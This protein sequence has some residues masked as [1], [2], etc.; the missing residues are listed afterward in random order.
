MEIIYN[1]LFLL[2]F[3]ILSI[4]LIFLL[5]SLIYFRKK[6]INNNKSIKKPFISIIIP[7]YNEEKDILET[8]ESLSKLT[9]NNIEILLINDGSSDKSQKIVE[10]FIQN[11]DKFKL[12]NNTK[13]IGKANSLNKGIKLAKGELIAC[14]DADTITDD[15]IFEKIIPYFDNKKVGAVV[16]SILVKKQN[17]LIQKGIAV[18]YFLMLSI[19][20]KIISFYNSVFVT[21]GQFSVF[22]KD[23]LVKIKGFDPNNMAEDNEIAFRIQKAKYLIKSCLE[24]KV[25]TSVPDNFKEL[26]VQRKRW[27]FGA[28]QTYFKHKNMMFKKQYSNFGIIAPITF[29]LIILGLIFMILY[30]FKIIYNVINLFISNYNFNVEE[31]LPKIFLIIVIF[32]IIVIFITYSEHIFKRVKGKK[33][34]LKFS[35]IIIFPT[36]FLIYQIYWA[37][38][39]WSYFRNKKIEWR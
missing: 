8:L 30:L 29:F 22:R 10:K 20:Q 27:Y 5:F 9:Y 38:A 35:G 12:I 17:N 7:F 6:I 23:V 37:K 4:Y 36:L 26:S 25:Y 16:T 21:P 18:E 2:I 19:F 14:S 13:N 11:K 32:T 39:F 15:N 1:S 31:I 33:L 3:I 28:I 24:A 34:N